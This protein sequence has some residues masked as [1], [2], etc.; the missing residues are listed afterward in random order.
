MK[1]KK[2]K[3]R[4]AQNEDTLPEMCE[5]RK[6]HKNDKVSFPSL[7]FMQKSKKEQREQQKQLSVQLSLGEWFSQ[8]HDVQICQSR[9][10]SG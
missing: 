10:S 5:T 9:W 3:E 2:S 7:P 6:V 4:N 1:K 8:V